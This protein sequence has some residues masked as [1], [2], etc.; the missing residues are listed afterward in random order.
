MRIDDDFHPRKLGAIVVAPDRTR[1]RLW[2]PANST[3]DASEVISVV[4]P[5]QSRSVP[6]NR[7]AN[8]FHVVEIDGVGP[9]QRYGYRVG[10]REIRPDPAS[11]FQPDSVHGLSQV[12]DSQFDWSDHD[13]Q[14]PPRED[15]VI[16]ELHVGTFTDAGTFLSAIPRLDELVKLGVTAV[17]LMP[18]ADC[19]GNWNWGYDG[20][21]LFAPQNSY[22]TPEDFRRLVDAAHAKGLAVILDVVYN[23]LGP[24]G[25]YLGEY[26]CYLSDLHHTTWGPGPAF[27]HPDHGDGVQRFFIANALHWYDEYHVDGL[28]V[29]AIHCMLDDSEPHVVRKLAESTRQWSDTSGR[30]AWLIA[31]SNVYDPEITQHVA[32]GGMGFDAQWSD[33][34]LHSLF[35]VVRPDEQLCHRAY[36]SG[37]DLRQVLDRGFV[38]QGRIR[39]ACQRMTPERRI[40]TASLVYS[41]QNHD[42]IGNHPLGQRLHQLTSAEK[43]AA[44]ATLLLLS[45]AIPMLFMGE[46][47]ACA[48]PFRFFVDFSDAHLRQAVIAGRQAEYPQHDWSS[49]RLPTDPESFHGSRLGT[50][51]DGSLLMRGWYKQLIEL[52]RRWR[53]SGLL[54]DEYLRT[55]CDVDAGQYEL[56]YDNGTE[57]AM[58]AVRLTDDSSPDPPLVSTDLRLILSSDLVRIHGR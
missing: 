18:V 2:C 6:M 8:G 17:E 29:D 25:N 44:A 22:G 23:H 39:E 7:E 45:P 58:V 28:R 43:Q 53:S 19:A 46:E 47:F 37:D 51:E 55:E 26:G 57:Q 42:F 54:A 20:V 24:E 15:W 14:P 31:E 33:D 52:R 32:E 13:W 16:Y 49:G 1:F 50:A 36:R 35:A 10:H 41:I 21:H 38:Y 3:V 9:G 4:L 48:H 11:R 34:F 40:D 56:F 5:D 12:I 30:K 27:D